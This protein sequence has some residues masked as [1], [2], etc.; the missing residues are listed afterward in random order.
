[1]SLMPREGKYVSPID[2]VYKQ[3][4]AEAAPTDFQSHSQSLSSCTGCTS[5]AGPCNKAHGEKSSKQP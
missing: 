5:T 2:S 4:D 1:M 3:T